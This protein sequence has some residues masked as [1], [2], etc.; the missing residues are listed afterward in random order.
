MNEVSCAN[1]A[2]IIT[3]FDPNKS[4]NFPK[5]AVE[6]IKQIYGMETIKPAPQKSPPDRLKK[7]QAIKGELIATGK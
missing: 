4:L 2:K 5:K 3:F 7:Y 1:K 6:N